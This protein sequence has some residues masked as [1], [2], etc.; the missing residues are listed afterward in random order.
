MVQ[1]RAASRISSG[2]VPPR[3]AA[4]ATSSP[5]VVASTK[6]SAGISASLWLLR[7]A[8]SVAAAR[9]PCSSGA[10][11]RKPN[12]RTTTSSGVA[13]GSRPRNESARASPVWTSAPTTRPSRVVPAIDVRRARPASWR[14]IVTRTAAARGSATPAAAA[15]PTNE[16]AVAGSAVLIARSSGRSRGRRSEVEAD[17]AGDRTARSRL[18][19]DAAARQAGRDRA[20]SLFRRRGAGPHGLHVL[21]R[22]HGRLPRRRQEHA[23]EEL[24]LVRREARRRR[25]AR[26]RGRR[27]C[28]PRRYRPSRPATGRPSASGRARRGSARRPRSPAAAPAAPAATPRG[29]PHAASPAP[30]GR[31]WPGR[32]CRFPPR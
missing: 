27:H 3:N 18:P 22:V 10:A 7:S 2:R 15:A 14:T 24:P 30:R 6:R 17:P 20:G 19:L 11:R 12:A 23:G 21:R 13:R 16:N 29:R 28:R 1:I 9:A 32:T 4:F 8:G 26:T 5:T 25:A 31:R